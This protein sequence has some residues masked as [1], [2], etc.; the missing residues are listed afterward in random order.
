MCARGGGR[1][2]M[3]RGREVLLSRPPV[4]LS[5]NS[6]ATWELTGAVR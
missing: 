1:G 4:L 5:G 3:R 6:L 2:E